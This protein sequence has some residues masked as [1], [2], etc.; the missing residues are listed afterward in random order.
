LNV[1][2]AEGGKDWQA[3]LVLE[4]QPG[5]YSYPAVIQTADG[6]VHTAYTWKRE[7]IKHVVIDPAKLSPRPLAGGNWPR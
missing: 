3:A 7:R 2:V 4:D 5:E 1:A 6:L